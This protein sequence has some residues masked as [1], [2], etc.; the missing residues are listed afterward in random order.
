MQ[1][2]KIVQTVVLLIIVAIA[3]SCTA[4]KEYTSKLFPGSQ[5]AVKD[6]QAVALRFLE[7][8]KVEEDKESWVTTDIIM[9]RDTVSKT[10]AL[11]NLAKVYPS[12]TAKSDSTL[13][14]S[15]TE[16]VKVTA[17]PKRTEPVVEEPVAKAANGNSVREKRTREN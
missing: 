12:T 1:T 8:D 13:K 16:T 3:A 2:A 17:A 11:D 9:G 14:T 10:L 6:S 7:L 5:A 15:N 4:T